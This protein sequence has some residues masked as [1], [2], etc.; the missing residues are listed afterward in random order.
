MSA[1]YGSATNE[2]D[3]PKTIFGFMGSGRKDAS[4]SAF[5]GIV[6]KVQ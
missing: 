3:L 2:Q 4:W 1:S 5:G 6:K